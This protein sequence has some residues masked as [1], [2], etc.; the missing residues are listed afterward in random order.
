MFYADTGIQHSSHFCALLFPLLIKV[1]LNSS[2]TYLISQN[3]TLEAWQ[4]LLNTIQEE[5]NRYKNSQSNVERW[6]KPLLSL[7]FTA[8]ENTFI[9]NCEFLKEVSYAT[10]EY[11]FS[12]QNKEI[13][14]KLLHNYRWKKE[15][16]KEEIIYLT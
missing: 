15:E 16:H 8:Y 9:D 7:N 1:L 5:I 11:G 10:I 3:K 12:E 4:Q 6:S 13:S 14:K 2:S